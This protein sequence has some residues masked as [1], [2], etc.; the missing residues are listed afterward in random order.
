MEDWVLVQDTLQGKAAFHTIVSKYHRTVFQLAY[1]FLRHG[2]DAE[3]ATQDTF[4]KA[5]RSL[6]QYAPLAPFGN[7]LLK[8]ATNTCLSRLR[9]RR[10]LPDILSL[11]AETTPEPVV[12]PDQAR[13]RLLH[14]VDEAVRALKPAHHAAFVLFHYQHLDYEGVADALEVPVSTV[15]NYLFRA[16]GTL[17]EYGIPPP[18]LALEGLP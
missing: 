4:L 6:H 10:R 12:P 9:A 8:I 11:G 18:P 17:R 16:R 7:W 5:Y 15:K 1:R 2:E 14:V 13:A 3:D